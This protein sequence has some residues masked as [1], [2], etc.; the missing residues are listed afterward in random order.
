MTTASQFTTNYL[1]LD[2]RLAR[3]GQLDTPCVIIDSVVVERNIE[4]MAAYCRKH[5]LRLRPHTKT[6]K[7]LKIAELQIAAGAGGLTVAKPGEAQVMAS[8]GEEILIAYPPVTRASLEVVRDLLTKG[9]VTVALDSQQA[10]ER[11]E[12]ALPEGGRRA[13]VLV[14]IDVGLGRTGVQSPAE[15]VRLAK[16]IDAS[17]RLRLR[18][19]F[20]YPGHI[21]KT[22]ENQTA[23][24]NEFSNVLEEHLQHWKNAGPH[25]QIVSG[26]STP[27]AYQ[28]HLVSGLTE[29]RP[30]TYV[31]ND[32]NTVHGG[33][34]SLSDCAVRLLTTVVSTAVK[35]Q[36][37]VDAGNKAISPDRC[38]PAPDTGHGFV[39]DLPG[40]K[41]THLSEEH[42]QIDVSSCE[43][44]PQ[45][46]DRLTI[47]PNHVCPT[48]NLTD[49]AWWIT[50]EGQ[51]EPLTIDARGMVR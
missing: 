4:R 1:S 39:C 31:Y 9:E 35:G 40:A 29:I 41:V 43:R 3:C 12:H 22:P 5:G 32:M 17:T 20:C 48:I 10:I 23:L 44:P 24:L 11:L 33:F 46:G 16:R 2:E 6:H 8:L 19:L 50:A 38:I 51:A 37:V 18:G 13:G 21:W 15:S 28:S 7:S 34:C 36:V 47:I 30:G 45:V 14:D 42:G 49:S 27:T 25:A 26:G